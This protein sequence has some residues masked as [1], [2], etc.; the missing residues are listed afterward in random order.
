MTRLELYEFIR[1]NNYVPRLWSAQEKQYV[2]DCLNRVETD[3]FLRPHTKEMIQA[4]VLDGQKHEQE[5]PVYVAGESARSSLWQ[6]MDQA[7]CGKL[8]EI[9]GLVRYKQIFTYQNETRGG[10]VI[11]GTGYPVSIEVNP[12][13]A[14]WSFHFLDI[15]TKQMVLANIARIQI[16]DVHKP[17]KEEKQ[18]RAIASAF[19]NVT[20]TLEVSCEKN[21]LER[22]CAAFAGYDRVVEYPPKEGRLR[23]T[24]TC[25][26]FDVEPIVQEILALG[27]YVVV[28]DPPFVKEQVVQAIRRGIEIC[29][30]NCQ[31]HSF[32]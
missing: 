7:V 8:K 15:E 18:Y 12:L 21:A 9:Q 23:M 11:R 25:Y 26:P 16:I 20:I 29:T 17:S 32:M 2:A 22:S 19:K 6:D 28:Q 4:Q 27:P 13:S 31:G 24:L 30:Q 5:M 10:K 14:N 1:K 3:V